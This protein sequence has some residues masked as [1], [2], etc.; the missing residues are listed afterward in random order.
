MLLQTRFCMADYYLHHFNNRAKTGYG[1]RHSIAPPCAVGWDG[2][3][4]PVATC[5]KQTITRIEI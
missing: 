3:A 4:A 2:F 1:K 5:S